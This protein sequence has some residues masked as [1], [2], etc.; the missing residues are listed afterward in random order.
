[1]SKD[2]II[3][4]TFTKSSGRPPYIEELQKLAPNQLINVPANHQGHIQLCAMIAANGILLK[5]TTTEVDYVAPSQIE[6][7]EIVYK[8]GILGS[9]RA[10]A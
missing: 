10:E 4:I 7:I 3:K 8:T 1:M 5:S 6:K 2:K 9:L